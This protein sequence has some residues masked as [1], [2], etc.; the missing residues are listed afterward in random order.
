MDV[1]PFYYQ[2][3]EL[4]RIMPMEPTSDTQVV[5][6][7]TVAPLTVVEKELDEAFD[8]FHY[9]P[10]LVAQDQNVKYNYKKTLSM[11]DCITV[12]FN[13]VDRA[14]IFISPGLFPT[15]NSIRKHFTSCCNRLGLVDLDIINALVYIRFF[16]DQY[17]R[18]NGI[19]KVIQYKDIV[20]F[21]YIS[22]SMLFDTPLN[23][24][25]W[26][27]MLGSWIIYDDPRDRIDIKDI[28]EGYQAL[29]AHTME[30]L[31]EMDFR[32]HYTNKMFNWSTN[33]LITE[34]NKSIESYKNTQ[35]RIVD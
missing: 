35:P 30:L 29:V 24:T 26:H 4:R 11:T 19:C 5:P 3:K 34:A 33:V 15:P 2:N 14:N 16:Q 25:E 23:K 31:V 7:V 1:L 21:I 6:S 9:L 18:K 8:V 13:V 12:F 32:T 17:C 10:C 20:S 28:D 22:Q 27:F